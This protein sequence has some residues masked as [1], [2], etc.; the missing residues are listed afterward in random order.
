MKESLV[1]V[2][3]CTPGDFAEGGTDAVLLAEHIAVSTSLNA[4]VRPLLTSNG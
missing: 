1:S 2:S 3:Y 4:C